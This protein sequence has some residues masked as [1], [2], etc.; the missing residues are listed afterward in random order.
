MLSL[1][2][3][4]RRA[5]RGVH[6][7]PRWDHDTY[8]GGLAIDAEDVDASAG[9]FTPGGRRARIDARPLR[10]PLALGLEG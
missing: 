3:A 4:K 10:E 2:D 1:D 8:V 7:V 6:E 5:V 9:V